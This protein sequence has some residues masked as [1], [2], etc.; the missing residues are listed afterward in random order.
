MTR[1]DVLLFHQHLFLF[2]LRGLCLSTVDDLNGRDKGTSGTGLSTFFSF[3]YWNIAALGFWFRVFEVLQSVLEVF[4]SSRLPDSWSC[5][6]NR[7]LSSSYSSSLMCLRSFF[8]LGFLIK[9]AFQRD[10]LL[11]A[12]SLGESHPSEQFG[13]KVTWTLSSLK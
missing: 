2:N 10:N 11:F 5:A 9:A 13:P 7:N 8:L 1:R 12:L 6:S 3:F 4:G